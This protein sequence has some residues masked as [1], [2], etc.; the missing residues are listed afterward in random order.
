MSPSMDSAQNVIKCF[1]YSFDIVD[2]VGQFEKVAPR[3]DPVQVF[4]VFSEKIDPILE[5][6][7]RVSIPWFYYTL[8]SQ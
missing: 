8:L 5:S 4:G 7:C 2:I 1:R 6:F 3:P